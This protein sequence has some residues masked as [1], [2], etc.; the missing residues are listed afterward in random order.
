M[1]RG[2]FA[3]RKLKQDRERFKKDKKEARSRRIKHDP[4]EGAPQGRAIVLKK[5]SRAVKQP[6]SGL[7]KCVVVQLLKNGKTVT[8]FVP[9]EGAIDIIDEHDQVLIE[10]IGGPQRGQMGD[11]PG[12]KFK[13]T[14]VNG[15]SL[16]EI[17]KGNKEKP[18]R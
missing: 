4:L 9:G 7:R 8:S 5:V 18:M 14:K 2:L 3:G 1:G 16:K 17:L 15:V 6:H 12:V 11:I 13:V 10:R